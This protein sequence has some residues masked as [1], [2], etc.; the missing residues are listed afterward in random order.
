MN[1]QFSRVREWMNENNVASLV[2]TDPANQFYLSGFKAL[3]YSRPILLI[4]DHETSAFIL[5][6]LEEKHAE[7]EAEVDNLY[8]YY[9]TPEMAGGNASND[10]TELLQQVLK[11]KHG[12]GE[13]IAFDLS[14]ASAR[15][16]MDVK[17]VGFNVADASK[18]IQ[19]LR[20]RKNPQEMETMKEAGKL[21]EVAVDKSIRTAAE[22]VTELEVDAAGNAELFAETAR[23]YPNA[24]LDLTVMTPSGPVRSVMP[25]VFS[26]T[27]KL[28]EG[29]V[30][31]HT[32]Q[33]GLN[34]YRA[35]LER[36]FVVGKASDRQK[37]A[38]H[39][40][41][42]AQEAALKMIK[43]GVQ[44]KE[45]DLA[46]RKVITEA[47]LE[48]YAIHRVG[49]AIG[50]SSHEEPHIR[51]DNSLELEEGM[52]FCIEPG[53]YIPGVGGFRHSDTVIITADGYE[54]ITEYPRDLKRLTI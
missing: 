6:S 54:L 24:S 30:A 7:A 3:I 20:Y 39:V 44:A 33:V 9:E 38:F 17:E 16:V 52:A 49:H 19:T 1:S 43:P 45:I 12:P 18:R 37:E 50:V 32:R 28:E 8:A 23:E 36:T 2:I 4:I 53:I 25:H 27:R 34:G 47:G 14:Y 29:D 41:V 21:V 40:M 31:I 26:N 10:P 11:Q 48:E 5:P 35:E 42:R 13:T 15:L 46:A 22:G 51:F